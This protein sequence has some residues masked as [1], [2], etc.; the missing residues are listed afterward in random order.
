MRSHDDDIRFSFFGNVNNC[1]CYFPFPN[2]EI[3]LDILGH[4]FIGHFLQRIFGFYFYLW[5]DVENSFALCSKISRW[6]DIF[7][8]VEQVKNTSLRQNRQGQLQRLLA[9]FVKIYG[10]EN[11]LKIRQPCFV[12][13][14]PYRQ[15]RAVRAMHNIFSH[16]AKKKSSHWFAAVCSDSYHIDIIF[17][18][19]G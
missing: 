10:D 9:L 17:R 8:D 13:L 18:G 4:K 3:S 5:H 19:I 1:C 7:D 15:N 16:T 14:N 2:D 6:Y 12:I 11:P